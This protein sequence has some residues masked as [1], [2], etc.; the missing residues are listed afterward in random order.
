LNLVGQG[1]LNQEPLKTPWIKLLSKVSSKDDMDEALHI[2]D[3]LQNAEFDSLA[4]T[5]ASVARWTHLPYD[6]EI[7]KHQTLQLIAD[8]LSACCKGDEAEI[9]AW[10]ETAKNIPTII[11]S[12]NKSIDGVQGLPQ[13]YGTKDSK[14]LSDLLRIVLLPS[15]SAASV[16]GLGYIAENELPA[17]LK[18][19]RLLNE[20]SLIYAVAPDV[21]HSIIRE[22]L[23]VAKEM[24]ET[25]RGWQAICAYAMDVSAS[26]E[27]DSD[28]TRSW[29]LSSSQSITLALESVTADAEQWNQW[30]NLLLEISGTIKESWFLERSK[31]FFGFLKAGKGCSPFVWGLL[32]E[33]TK[34]AL[35]KDTTQ[36]L[37]ELEIFSHFL[38]DAVKI[39]HSRVDTT[40]KNPQSLDKI[41]AG[42]DANKPT[43]TL[44]NPSELTPRR[45]DFDLLEI[46]HFAGQSD[47]NQPEISLKEGQ[48]YRRKFAPVKGPYGLSPGQFTASTESYEHQL[49]P[50]QKNI[51]LAGTIDDMYA[52]Y[53][54]TEDGSVTV[55]LL[56]RAPVNFWLPIAIDEIVELEKGERYRLQ[57]KL[58]IPLEQSFELENESGPLIPS[59]LT[60]EEQINLRSSPFQKW[61]TQRVLEEERLRRQEAE[62]SQRRKNDAEQ[63]RQEAARE[64]L[65]AAKEKISNLVFL[66]AVILSPWIWL[67]F[68][69]WNLG[70]KHFYILG[71]AS[72][73]MA[74]LSFFLVRFRYSG[75]S[76]DDIQVACVLGWGLV[77]AAG[78]LGSLNS[79]VETAG[80]LGLL[81]AIVLFFLG[82]VMAFLTQAE[83]SP[84]FENR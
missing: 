49:I 83:D 26:V 27:T 33:A 81:F 20:I 43:W 10:C 59:L 30:K 84:F 78:G 55:T 56:K 82:V 64:H 7:W 69:F 53:E 67:I 17:L 31:A 34:K 23:D 73:W 54:G 25:A 11:S 57:L 74:A 46:E 58:A 12:I 19:S 22:S 38:T 51:Q 21:I 32:S 9:K 77:S 4:L 65:R 28:S 75:W 40:V 14:L 36:P 62:I 37:P 13:V 80:F 63:R 52:L 24:A 76:S 45:S 71:I 41:I 70:L 68:L 15:R 39:S 16:D 5:I 61:S 50:N 72:P 42:I 1:L 66:V 44:I 8:S 18:Y 79:L 29:Q 2:A 48:T 60:T 3:S 6:R 35:P 47:P